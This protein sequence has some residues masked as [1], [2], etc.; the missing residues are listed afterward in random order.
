MNSI[1][2]IVYLEYIELLPK[3]ISVENI[4]KYHAIR[5]M[6]SFSHFVLGLSVL[7][8]LCNVTLFVL[9]V[10]YA[11]LSQLIATHKNIMTGTNK[12]QRC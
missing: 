11:K 7:M 10:R 4:S 6:E 9:N 12:I 5:A 1:L 2:D 8:S 3:Y